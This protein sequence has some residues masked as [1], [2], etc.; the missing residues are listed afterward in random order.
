MGVL[1]ASPNHHSE[2]VRGIDLILRINA[3]IDGLVDLVLGFGTTI[4]R[5]LA[6][7]RSAWRVPQY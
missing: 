3:S 5:R 2:R 7:L 1:A 6:K 4:S